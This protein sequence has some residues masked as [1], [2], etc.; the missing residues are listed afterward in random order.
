MIL[1]SFFL[2]TLSNNF[3]FSQQ[4]IFDLQKINVKDGL[5]ARQ[6]YDIV[7]DN[8]GFIWISTRLGI[9]RY[10]GYSFTT[11]SCKYLNSPDRNPANIFI[12]SQNRLVSYMEVF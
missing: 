7:Q 9:H 1:Y 2:I 12:D 5:P 8:E 4:Y 11:Y 3:L 10:D 6:V